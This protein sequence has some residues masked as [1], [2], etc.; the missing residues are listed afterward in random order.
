MAKITAPVAPITS[1]ARV[2]VSISVWDKAEN[3]Y[4]YSSRVSA[5]GESSFSVD[6]P[7]VVLEQFPLDQFIPVWMSQARQQYI[8]AI[9]EAK[10]N[11]LAE[12]LNTKAQE[13]AEIS[14]TTPA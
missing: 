8:T 9:I 6:I 7:L 13:N 3:D 5:K 1:I 10:A 2:Q 12:E 14:S 4:P 11:K